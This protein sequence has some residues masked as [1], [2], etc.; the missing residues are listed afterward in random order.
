MTDSF[1][2]AHTVSERETDVGQINV[3]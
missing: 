1:P 3:H 2:Q